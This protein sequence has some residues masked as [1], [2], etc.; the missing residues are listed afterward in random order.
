MPRTIPRPRV[1]FSRRFYFRLRGEMIEIDA[2]V[3]IGDPWADRTDL[4]S[5]G[6]SVCRARGLTLALRLTG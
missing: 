5:L 1:L 6:W 2:V 3:A 4:Q